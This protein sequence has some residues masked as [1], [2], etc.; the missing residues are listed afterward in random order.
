MDTEKLEEQCVSG[1][2]RDVR[3]AGV[4]LKIVQGNLEIRK[5]LGKD[6]D[7]LSEFLNKQCCVRFYSGQYRVRC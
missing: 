3:V 5:D 6:L 2:P 7:V 4:E 1:V